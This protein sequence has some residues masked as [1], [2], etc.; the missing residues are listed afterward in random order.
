MTIEFFF[1]HLDQTRLMQENIFKIY[2]C[3]H[4]TQKKPT[5]TEPQCDVS[6][7]KPEKRI[8]CSHRKS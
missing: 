4:N 2:L 1:L 7:Q 5:E 6:S 3:L 8:V